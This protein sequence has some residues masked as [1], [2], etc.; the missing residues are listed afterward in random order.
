MKKIL[1]VLGAIFLVIVLLGIIG[2]SILAVK[3][4]ALD[5]ESKSYVDTVAPIILANLSK[6]TLFEYADDQLKNSVK[7]E[8]F[9]KMFNWFSK[10]GNFV[11]YKEPKG[12]ANISITTE[13]GKVITGYYEVFAE[14]ETGPAT[15][16]II[17]IKRGNDWKIIGF[18]I[19]SPA[20]FNQ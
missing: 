10:L 1:M 5:K 16:R 17:I 18:H 9:E 2:F 14:F 8:E 19:N 20:L 4:S 12:Q 11:E 15:V 6:E 3:G 13:S 7:P